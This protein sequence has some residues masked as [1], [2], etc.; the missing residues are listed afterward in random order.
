MPETIYCWRCRIDIPMLTEVEWA[1]LSPHLTDTVERIK[2]YRQ[3]H[4]CSLQ[5]ALEK[6]LG[7][8]L[9]VYEHLTGFKETNP[10]ALG[11][12]GAASMALPARRVG[13][14]SALHK[15]SSARCA[16]QN[17]SRAAPV[18]LKL[19]ARSQ[20]AS[21]RTRPNADVGEGQVQGGCSHAMA[22]DPR[23]EAI[24]RRRRILATLRC[25]LR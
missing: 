10:N 16:A 24:A 23:A 12:T 1:T 25:S 15:R 17:E 9:E 22:A 6:G 14:R 4:S 21:A 8:A 13:S 20:R 19:R 18:T 5:E 2:S 3:Q 11:I 7:D